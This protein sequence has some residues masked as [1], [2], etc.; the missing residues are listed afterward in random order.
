MADLRELYQQIILDH[1]RNPRFFGIKENA[2]LHKSCYNP[3]CGDKIEVFC[4]Q[5]KG[6]ITHLT[7]T[8]EGCAISVASGSLMAEALQGLTVQEAKL[9]FYNYQAL[10]TGEDLPYVDSDLGKLRIME[11]VRQFPMRVKCAT[12]SWHAFMGALEEKE[13]IIQTESKEENNE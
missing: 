3:L 7:F 4:E 1:S 6:V 2:V 9:L 10:V 8:G 12:C 13:G 11:S 5:Q